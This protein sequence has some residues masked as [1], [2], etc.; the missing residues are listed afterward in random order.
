MG[1][2][3]WAFAEVRRDGVWQWVRGVFPD[4]DPREVDEVFPNRSYALFG[5]LADVRNYSRS[6]VIAEMRGMPFDISAGLY[7]QHPDEYGSWLSL[8]ELLAYDYD[9]VFWDRRVTRTTFNPVSGGSVTDG[10]ALAEEGEGEHVTLREFLGEGFFARLD[11]LAELGAPEDVRIV[12]W[13]SW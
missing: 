7:D 12:F 6:P 5:F 2:D 4:A 13:F 9:Q 10:A 3:I 11:R 8:A 1:T